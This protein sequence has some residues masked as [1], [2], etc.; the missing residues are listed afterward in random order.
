M[1]PEYRDLITK[2][3]TTDKHFLNLFDKHNA[4]DQKIKNMESHV[5][6]GTPEEIEILKKEKLNLKD[7]LYAVLKKSQG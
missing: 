6:S 1:F 2:L 7:Q 5:E 4:L 3:K